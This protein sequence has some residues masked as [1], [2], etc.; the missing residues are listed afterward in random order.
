MKAPIPLEEKLSLISDFTK[1]TFTE[2][3]TKIDPMVTNAL[4]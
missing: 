1:V 3:E 4:F 2:K